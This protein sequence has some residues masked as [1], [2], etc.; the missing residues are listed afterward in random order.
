MHEI[1]IED[2]IP[3]PSIPSTW[4]FIR[5]MKDE[6]SFVT[7][8]KKEASI[9]QS[10]LKQGTRVTIRY[11][12]EGKIRVWKRPIKSATTPKSGVK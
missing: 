10:S 8:A 9:R 11:I 5:K 1:V 4:G 2:G 3:I 7:D 6:Q 12:G